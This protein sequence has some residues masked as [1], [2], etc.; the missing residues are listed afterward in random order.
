MEVEN[1]TRTEFGK[2][3]FINKYKQPDE[4]FLEFVERVSGGNKAIAKLIIE[5]KFFCGG[6]IAANRGLGHLKRVCYS[7]CF[8]N[9]IL[10][11]SIEGIF[12][13]AKEMAR[14]FSTGGGCG[15]TV[16][17]LSPRGAKVRNAAK[18][19]TG[20]V[21][22]ME[23]YDV[24]SKLIGAEGRRAALMMSLDCHH[25]DLE[26]FIDI[27]KNLDNITK[28]NISVMF[29]DDFMQAVMNDSDFE[30]FYTRKETGETLRKT[31]N[32]REVFMKLA[33]NNWEM[34][35]P[36]CLFWDRIEQ[37][38]LVS[39]DP[40]FKYSGV[41]PCLVGGTLI[42]TT[43]GNIPIKDLVGTQPFVYCMDEDGKLIIEQAKS[44]IKTKSNAELIK[45]N[46]KRGEI[47]CT[48][49]HEIYTLNRGWV[50]AKELSPK[51]KLNGLGRSMKNEKYCKLKLTS[52]KSYHSEHRFIAGYFTDID[53]KDVHHI[54]E[55][56]LH[57][58]W[59]NLEVLEHG[60]HSVLTNVGHEPYADRDGDTGRYISKEKKKKREHLEVNKEKLGVNFIVD[61]VEYLDYTEDVYDIMMPENHNFV[62]NDIIVHNCG[63][64]PLLAYGNC[65]LSSINLAEFEKDGGVDWKSLKDATKAAVIYLNEV[66]D[67]GV[68][69]LPLP[70]H[71]ETCKN[72]RQIGLGVMGWADLLIK[73]KIRYG[74]P[75]SIELADKIGEFMTSCALEQSAE[76]AKE[77]GA[78]PMY[79]DKVLE[80]S[81]FKAHTNPELTEMVKEY[82]LRNCAL[83]SIAPTGSI[84]NVLSVSGGIE[85]I[86]ANSYMRKTESL[87]GQEY[88]YKVY[89][90]IVEDFMAENNIDNEVNLPDY[91]VTAPN[92]PYTE[93]IA[94]QAAWQKHIDAA[95][96]STVNL[97]EWITV[98][99]VFDLY[100]EAWKQ[101]L[102]GVTIYRDNCNRAG[103]LVNKTDEDE[104]VAPPEE[105]RPLSVL[106]R[107][108]V[109]QVYDDVIGR[110]R[111]LITGCGSLHACADFDPV[112][113]ELCETFLSKG[114]EGGC[115]SW[116]VFGSRMISR[117][118]RLGDTI[119][120]IV[121]Q[122][123]SCPSCPSYMVRRA[124]KH[125]VSPGNCC[126]AAVGIALQDMYNQL[127][128]EMNGDDYDEFELVD[129]AINQTFNIPEPKC[130]TCEDQAA[131]KELQEFLD[132]ATNLKN[133]V[134]NNMGVCPK[135][136][137]KTYIAEGGCGHC[138]NDDCG[139][140]GCD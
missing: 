57:N 66:L 62:A 33:Q 124:T 69:F 125:D 118:M 13:C 89:T 115:N 135:C 111:K 133:E 9:E 50:Q 6:R 83:M 123:K 72:W 139:F 122:A 74:S 17:K 7:N 79:S 136:G 82:G 32:A 140:S 77:Y 80:S 117:A 27:K 97:P 73:L 54:D 107:G 92:I 47:I 96:S 68:E 127:Q 106:K 64:Q 21:S 138:V 22:F 36:G 84:S 12:D 51:D 2:D 121:D 45:V 18:E 56:P 63:E 119:E 26:E 71:K 48:P 137:Q 93:R 49:D 24:T 39:E 120:G 109:V 110:K 40:K 31:V 91:F 87:H 41:N 16:S 98:E 81:F 65:M 14:T 55:N 130:K 61:S 70:Q 128:D 76:L 105:T 4:T 28:A 100:L 44:V 59:S 112:D 67:E 25:P 75:E 88:W 129:E 108:D 86:F 95:I 60:E 30:L 29:T 103:V 78:Y 23:L 94:M 134:E 116:M 5:K 20:A 3:V 114:S 58:V 10:E 52:D 132:G 102:K 101:G 85:P 90:P 131:L 11:D 1:W 46:F 8:C 42:Q 43:E 37:Y 113:G 38:N 15:I 53:G 34:A 19:T 99:Q 126:P 104:E 35:E